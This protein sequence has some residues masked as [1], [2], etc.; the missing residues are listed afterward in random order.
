MSLLIHILLMMGDLTVNY[1]FIN[2]YGEII[3]KLTMINMTMTNKKHDYK[4]LIW[5]YY[6]S[7]IYGYVR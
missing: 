6:P 2:Y 7:T 3:N 4:I 5:I 1:N